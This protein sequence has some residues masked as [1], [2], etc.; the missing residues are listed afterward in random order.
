VPVTNGTLGAWSTNGLPA[1]DYVLRLT[2]LD[3]SGGTKTS[4][5]SVTVK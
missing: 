4:T 1:G 5:V 3:T 2:V